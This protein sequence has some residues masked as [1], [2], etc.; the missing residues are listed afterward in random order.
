[1]NQDGRV[2]RKVERGDFEQFKLGLYIGV[3]RSGNM[4]KGI[5]RSNTRDATDGIPQGTSHYR[6]MQNP[7]NND[8]PGILEDNFVNK[9]RS[10]GVS[11]TRM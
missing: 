5:K 8:C 1:L 3:V 11:D 7:P 9:H 2:A 6:G 10:D 4:R